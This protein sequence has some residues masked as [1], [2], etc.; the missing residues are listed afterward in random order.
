MLIVFARWIK[1]LCTSGQ[2]MLEDTGVTRK[3]GAWI[4]SLNYESS[5]VSEDKVDN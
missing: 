4:R 2:G 1:R 5:I 3:T